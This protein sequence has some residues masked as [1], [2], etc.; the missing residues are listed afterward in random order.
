[1]NQNDTQ[2]T[3]LYLTFL[4]G[5]ELLAIDVSKVREVL[6]LCHIT[7]VP[8]APD[9]MRGIINV[10]GNVLPVID[11]RCRFDM[12]AVEST[13]DTRIVVLEVNI[14]GNEVII[15]ALADSVHEVVDI[16]SDHIG[17]PPRSGMAW[18]IDF[19]K[20]IG[21]QDDR[22]L[23]LMDIDRIFSSENT[24]HI[25]SKGLTDEV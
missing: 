15:G 7:R 20:G 17:P 9:Y 1:M 21:R 22:F 13:V 25:V 11:L 14:D 23:L 8:K 5:D 3:T 16:E 18:C 24:E 19:I 12:E 2:Q 6:D 4:L 10:R